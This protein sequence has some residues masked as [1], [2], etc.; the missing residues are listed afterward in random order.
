MSEK[1]LFPYLDAWRSLLR[2]HT[3]AISRI[4]EDLAEAGGPFPSP[5]TMCSL[6]FPLRPKGGCAWLSLQNA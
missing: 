6:S 4:E 3:V 1:V 2:A 5:P